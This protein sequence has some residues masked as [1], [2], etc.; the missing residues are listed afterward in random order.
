MSVELQIVVVNVE[1]R[2]APEHQFPTGLNDSYAAL[3]WTAGMASSLRIS[4]QKGFIVGGD[5]AGANLATVCAM[6]ARDDPFFTGHPVTGQLV[7]QPSVI[8]PDACPEKYKSE[9]CSMEEF[10]DGPL[11]T[12]DILMQCRALLKAPPDDPRISPL[13]F[14]SH[15]GVAPAF[16][17]YNG[18]DPLRDDARLWAKVLSEAGVKVKTECYPGVPHGFYYSFP[19]ISLARRVD[20]DTREGLRWLLAGAH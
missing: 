5:S 2:L 3:Q 4:L 1:Y 12:R 19:M 6:L 20:Q 11:L 17:T 18:R 14:R 9:L 16:I 10:K 15:A 13:L 8:H 7:R